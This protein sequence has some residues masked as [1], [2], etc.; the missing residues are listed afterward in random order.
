MAIGQSDSQ[1][2]VI[3]IFNTYVLIL[4][5]Y[6][7][8]THSYFCIRKYYLIRF[9]LLLKKKLSPFRQNNRQT[10]SSSDSSPLFYF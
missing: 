7:L 8:V 3:N 1:I 2:E 9:F 5:Y 10:I 6:L 4:S